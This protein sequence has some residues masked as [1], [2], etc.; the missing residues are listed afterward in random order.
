MWTPVEGATV[1]AG[2]SAEHASAPRTAAK[3]PALF[4]SSS[5]GCC[6]A[7]VWQQRFCYQAERETDERISDKAIEGVKAL[8]KTACI[9]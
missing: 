2:H 9:A 3:T 1:T 5:C 6:Q 4:I 7:T 8:W